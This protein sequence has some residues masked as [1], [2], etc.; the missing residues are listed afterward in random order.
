MHFWK[1]ILKN[2]ATMH[3]C[4]THILKIIIVRRN[5]YGILIRETYTP[6]VVLFNYQL[7]ISLEGSQTFIISEFLI[8]M[9]AVLSGLWVADAL[10]IFAQKVP[11]PNNV[12]AFMK[13]DTASKVAV[14]GL[15]GLSA[16][17]GVKLLN[18]GRDLFL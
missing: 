12:D 2:T 15:V 4:T 16:I 1:T 9:D 10:Y 13:G 18:K 8:K 11:V 7:W 3:R 5:T 14:G 17:L 6:P